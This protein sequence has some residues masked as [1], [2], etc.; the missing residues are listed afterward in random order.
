[1]K[2]TLL[3][4]FFLISVSSPVFAQSVEE[5]AIREVLTRQNVNWNDGNI[6]AFMEDYWKS[7]SL[8]FIGKNGVV[9][10][11][12]ATKDRYF[13]NYPDRKTMGQLAFDIKK[14]NL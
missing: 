12:Q 4:T 14:V 3:Y 2:K 13:R 10:G 7:D 11:W 8:M 9:Y 5:T 6:E 1:M